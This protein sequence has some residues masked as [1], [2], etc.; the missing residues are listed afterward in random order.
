MRRLQRPVLLDDLEIYD[1]NKESRDKVVNII[2]KVNPDFII[3]HDPEDY[4]PDHNAVSKLVFD[5]SF[6]AKYDSQLYVGR[7][8]AH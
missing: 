4:M 8:T 7:K 6:A 3:T 1:N 2:R 5:A